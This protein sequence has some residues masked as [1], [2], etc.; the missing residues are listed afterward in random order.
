MGTP[1]RIR[2]HRGQIT[3]KLGKVPEGCVAITNMC[4]LDSFPWYGASLPL[5]VSSLWGVFSD[6]KGQVNIRERWLEEGGSGCLDFKSWTW[7]EPR[8][9]VSGWFFLH[10]RWLCAC[11]GCGAQ[12]LPGGLKP[13]ES[14]LQ[15]GS[16][17]GQPHQ[18]W[19]SRKEPWLLLSPRRWHTWQST[20]TI[21]NKASF[22]RPM[23]VML[24]CSGQ[25]RNPTD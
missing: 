9:P 15:T 3:L 22:L 4:E 21:A 20:V 5:G 18:Q 1:G 7:G 24:E 14:G 11:S 23:L 16:R 8:E 19:E 2:N 13:A 10:H 6:F 12:R 25:F 17:G